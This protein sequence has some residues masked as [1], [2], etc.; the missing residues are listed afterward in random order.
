M[1]IE[2]IDTLAPKNGGAFPMVMGKD[3]E[4]NGKRLPEAL[5]DLE[6]AAGDIESATNS[7]IDAIFGDQQ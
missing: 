2:L 4:V 7:D 3:V 5:E 6:T 1:A